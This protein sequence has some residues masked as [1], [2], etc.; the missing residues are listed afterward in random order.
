MLKKLLL[1]VYIIFFVGF[2]AKA[3][4]WGWDQEGEGIKFAY[5][6]QYHASQYKVFKQQDWQAP[7]FDEQGQVTTGLNAITSEV[8]PGFGVGMALLTSIHKQVELR[9]S[10]TFVLND[11]VLTYRYQQ[12]GGFVLPVYKID[13]KVRAAVVDLP[14]A[15][16]LRSDRRKNFA[17]YVL[18]GSKYSINLSSAG[19]AEDAEKVA[20]EKLIRN[21]KTFFSYEAGLGIDF[22]FE[23][24]KLSPEV[25]YA[26]SFGSV[27]EQENTAFSRPIDKL[28]LRNVTFSLYIQ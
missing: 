8:N 21:K 16:K 27:L 6:L 24:F 18:A 1:L 20:F 13:K 2:A 11:R 3:Q 9:L 28:M 10:P 23:H 25:K 14:L 4:H 15:V 7:F 22:H 5:T 12:T 19:S 26:S 17:M